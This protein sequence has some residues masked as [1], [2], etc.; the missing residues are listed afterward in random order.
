MG[1]TTDGHANSSFIV[2]VRRNR[3][4]LEITLQDVRTRRL[5]SFGAWESL[6]AELQRASGELELDIQLAQAALPALKKP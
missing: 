5:L 3:K 6:F 1:D 4:G 2:R